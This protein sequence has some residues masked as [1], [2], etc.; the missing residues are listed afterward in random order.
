MTDKKI[1]NVVYKKQDS[2]H[3]TQPAKTKREFHCIRQ[4]QSVTAQQHEDLNSK[5]RRWRARQ[6]TQNLDKS[7]RNSKGSV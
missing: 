3:D 5:E 6:T 7:E 1:L 4:E 2:W